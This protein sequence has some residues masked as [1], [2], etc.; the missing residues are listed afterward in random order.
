MLGLGETREEVS[1]ALRELRA[2][3]VGSVTVGQYLSPSPRH[4]AVARYATP[5]EFDEIG[6]EA[7]SL[8]FR[9]VASAPLARSSFRAGEALP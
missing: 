9:H 7:R 3:G 5:E 4:L 8:G 1:A 6:D 2:A